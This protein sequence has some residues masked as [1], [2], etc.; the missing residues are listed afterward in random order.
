LKLVAFAAVLLAIGWNSTAGKRIAL[1]AGLAGAGLPAALTANL[2]NMFELAGGRVQ[3]SL[4][5]VCGSCAPQ[6]GGYLSGRYFERS[7]VA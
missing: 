6:L 7:A 3:G 1:N 4:Y 5:A 2:T